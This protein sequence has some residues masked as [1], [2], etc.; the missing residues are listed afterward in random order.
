[1][2]SAI[3]AT[4]NPYGGAEEFVKAGWTL[5]FST[6][7]ESDDK[8]A[9]V[10]LEGAQ[11]MLGTD[12][13]EFLPENARPFKGAGVVFYVKLPG[14]T[15]IDGVY[16]KH[17]RAGVVTDALRDRPWGERAFRA[18]IAGYKFLVVRG[19]QVS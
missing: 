6:P 18:T 8:L 12:A 11:V 7:P 2:L 1:M 3:L 13:P 5:A 14:G 9:I 17:L 19:E 10:E 4:P 16:E 15:D